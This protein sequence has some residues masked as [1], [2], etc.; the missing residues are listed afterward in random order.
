M[1]TKL[2]LADRK[3]P[4]KPQKLPMPFLFRARC[5]YCM[6]HPEFY[7]VLFDRMILDDFDYARYEM[8]YDLLLVIPPIDNYRFDPIQQRFIRSIGFIRSK[9][10]RPAISISG[11]P[12]RTSKDTDLWEQ[13]ITDGLTCK[14]GKSSWLFKGL[15][16][17]CCENRRSRTNAPIPIRLAPY[18]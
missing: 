8:H 3:E 15:T 10:F 5:K 9:P 16:I 11:L 17:A 6:G 7:I 1:G 4:N 12:W 18:R 2:V 14:C 13:S